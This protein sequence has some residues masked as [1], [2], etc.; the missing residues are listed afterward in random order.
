MSTCHCVS[1]AMGSHD[2]TVDM[3]APF[4]LPNRDDRWVCIDTCIATEIGRLWHQGVITLNSCCGHGKRPPSVIV[5]ADSYDRMDALGYKWELAPSG[6]RAHRLQRVVSQSATPSELP[7]TPN[8]DVPITC[9][10]TLFEN[11]RL[12]LDDTRHVMNA[13]I[14]NG[15]MASDAYIV[16]LLL[17][18]IE[19]CRDALADRPAPEDAS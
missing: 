13:R 1:V 10:T 18:E 7:T 17:D 9:R 2:N 19:C 15:W 6:L 16:L 11:G 12:N 4:D 5:A 14:K 3:R 8:L